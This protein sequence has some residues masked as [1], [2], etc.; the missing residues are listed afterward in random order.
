ME[1]SA[2]TYVF[3]EFGTRKARSTADVFQNFYDFWNY[4]L[5]VCK[6]QHPE[7]HGKRLC[8]QCFPWF[9]QPNSWQTLVLHMLSKM[10]IITGT[11][12][13]E[14]LETVKHRNSWNTLGLL[15][16]SICFFCFGLAQPSGHSSRN[17]GNSDFTN[18]V[19]L[20]NSWKTFVLH[21][22]SMTVCILDSHSP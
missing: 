3:H 7:I 4:D 5:K 6:L 13:S 11:M 1:N 20:P 15:T 10:S 9:L 12:S 18:I 22:L 16:V 17:H 2:V 21:M 19:L 14:S 8:Y